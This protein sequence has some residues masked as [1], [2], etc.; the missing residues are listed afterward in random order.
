M[1]NPILFILDKMLYKGSLTFELSQ[2]LSVSS[3][4]NFNVFLLGTSLV[5]QT[6][7]NQPAMQETQVPSLGWEDTLD[8]ET[9][10]QFFNFIY[11]VY[12]LF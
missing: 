3:V 6:V 1:Y 2:S 8:K 12:F 9:L 7:K 10:V 11:L 4:C 5:S